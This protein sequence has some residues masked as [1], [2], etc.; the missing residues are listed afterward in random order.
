MANETTFTYDMVPGTVHLV[1]IEGTLDVKKNGDIILQPQ[2]TSNPND[3]LAWS[4]FKRIF[5]FSIVWVWGFFVA[6]AINW[7]GPLF[8]IWEGELGVS[9]GQLGNAIAFGFLFL[10]IG[11][12]VIQPTALKLG[13]R[14]VYIAGTIICI[15]SLAVGSQATSIDSIYAFKILVGFSASPCDSLVEL[16]A[17]DLFFQHE[18]STVIASLIL[19]LYAGSFIGPIIAGYIVDSIGWIWCFYIQ[20]IIYSSFLLFQ[21]F[22]MEDTT[23]RRHLDGE[24]LEEDIL[25]QIRSSEISD[26]STDKKQPSSEPVA[27]EVSDEESSSSKIARKTYLQKLNLIQTDQNDV[28]SWL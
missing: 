8:G 18:R 2:P 4:R 15:V 22:F 1:D 20:I 7:I 9:M 24:D 3:P 25:K 27:M 11:V 12:L 19:A 14:L 6:I 16:S 13:K 26:S 21:F 10:G 28:R 5:Q 17:T 23:F